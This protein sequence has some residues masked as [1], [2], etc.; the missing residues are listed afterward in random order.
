MKYL[1]TLM[2]ALALSGAMAL[3]QPTPAPTPK[4]PPLFKGDRG[5]DDG[6]TRSVQGNVQVQDSD[7]PVGGAIV[8]LKDMRT[9][10][11]RSFITKED[12]AYFFQGLATNV[13][14][15]LKAESKEVG[16]SPIKTLS[17]YDSRK[18]A[19]INLKVE[20]KASK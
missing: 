14:Y 3:A 4:N 2:A 17:V 1:L 12:G 11:I 15:E 16:D 7:K 8:K 6:N 10:Q 19:I 18:V 9:L 5:K 13:D 20:P